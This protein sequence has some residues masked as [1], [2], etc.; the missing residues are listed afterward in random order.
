VLDES[1]STLAF[2]VSDNGILWGEFGL[3]GKRLPYRSAVEIPLLMRGPDRLDP[4]G[5]ERVVSNVDI[6][7]TILARARRSWPGCS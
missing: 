6:A 4:S 1:D 7:P 3:T 5:D 2:F